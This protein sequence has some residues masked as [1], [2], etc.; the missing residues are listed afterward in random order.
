M[1]VQAALE[2]VHA[3]AAS[4]EG[5]STTKHLFARADVVLAWYK[6]DFGTHTVPL[7]NEMSLLNSASK[8]I[9]LWEGPAESEHYSQW[10][11]EEQKQRKAQLSVEERIA[12]GWGRTIAKLLLQEI[13]SARMELSMRND[14]C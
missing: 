10:L 11:A 4:L 13:A 1:C 7:I 14:H 8:L 12:S 5:P 3:V 6:D 9:D 2:N